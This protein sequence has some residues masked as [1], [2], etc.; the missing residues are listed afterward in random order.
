MPKAAQDLRLQ[1]INFESALKR[2]IAAPPPP[3]SKK[4][5]QEKATKKPRQK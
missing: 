5:K 3:T 1:G 2:M 4:A